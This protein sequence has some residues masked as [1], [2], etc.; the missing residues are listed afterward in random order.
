LSHEHLERGADFPASRGKRIPG[1]DRFRLAA[2]WPRYDCIG[3]ISLAE[4]LGAPS[5]CHESDT[6]AE[7]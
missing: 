7:L 5:L 4:R 3:D 2:A 6:Q 1:G